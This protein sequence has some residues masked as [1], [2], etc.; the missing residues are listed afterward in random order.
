M[1]CIIDCDPGIDDILAIILA[2]KLPNFNIKAITTVY[3]NSSVINTSKNAIIT[4]ELIDAPEIPVARGCIEPI[5]RNLRFPK[6]DFTDETINPHGIDGKANLDIKEPTR[7]LSRF[8][9]IDLIINIIRSNPNKI[10]II[11]LGP[12]T[13]IALA[14]LKDPEIIKLIREIIIMGGAIEEKG[15]VTPFSEFNINSDAEAA[16]IVFNKAN[17]KITLVP[18]DVTRKIIF[19]KFELFRKN[20]PYHQ[21]IFNL[22]EYYSKFHNKI[23]GFKGCFLHDPFTIGIAYDRSFAKTKKLSLDV[24]IEN[25]IKYGMIKLNSNLNSELNK[26]CVCI[27]ISKQ[28]KDRFLELFVNSL[29][30]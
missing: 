19:D 29:L 21:F 14:F 20:D 18:L 13:N 1:Q 30:K 23:Y 26:I 25:K 4:L 16:K 6:F 22:L 2:N 11:S 24:E 9:A 17:R 7:K 28:Q 5:I 12:L 8:H 3:G 15:N 27:D 10:T